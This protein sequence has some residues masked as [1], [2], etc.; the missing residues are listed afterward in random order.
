MSAPRPTIRPA[1]PTIRP[2]HHTIRPAHPTIRP[3]HHAEASRLSALALHAKAHWGYSPAFMQAC[4]AELTVSS[5]QI[6]QGIFVVA[7][8][9]Q[10]VVGFYALLAAAPDEWELDALFVE[11]AW[12]RTG[13]GRRLLDHARIGAATAGATS[14]VIQA[15]PNAA[16]FY[17]AAGAIPNGMR[18][19]ASIANR[20]LP[21]FRL[22]L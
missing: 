18:P 2:A 9:A 1:H 13:I 19:S 7:E 17:V 20:L 14:L 15:D 21:V 16:P 5:E 10:D 3:A 22:A 12:I 4:R 6:A 11:P 8:I